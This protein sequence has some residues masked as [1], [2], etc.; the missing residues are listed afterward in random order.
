MLGL[1]VLVLLTRGSAGGNELNPSPSVRIFKSAGLV[2][3]LCQR[4]VARAALSSDGASYEMAIRKYNVAVSGWRAEARG[5]RR[6]V[7][8]PGLKG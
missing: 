6:I 3:A 2:S 5:L 4:E 7:V 8:T 1:S